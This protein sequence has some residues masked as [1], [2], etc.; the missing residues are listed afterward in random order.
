M[1]ETYALSGYSP[2][3][4]VL[5]YTLGKGFAAGRAP[6]PQSGGAPGRFRPRE[7][8]SLKPLARSLPWQAW[9]GLEVQQVLRSA[10]VHVPEL[11]PSQ[12]GLQQFHPESPEFGE[13]LAAAW[14]QGRLVVP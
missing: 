3:Y 10:L 9:A 8:P 5:R 1:Q 12:L 2:C 13:G 14:V 4:T 6:L 7:G 11:A